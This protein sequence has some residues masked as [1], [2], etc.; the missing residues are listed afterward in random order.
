MQKIKIPKK[1]KFTFF[2][3]VSFANFLVFSNFT[4]DIIKIKDG[5][6]KPFRFNFSNGRL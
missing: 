5:F 1:R 3:I 2:D 6:I 4:S